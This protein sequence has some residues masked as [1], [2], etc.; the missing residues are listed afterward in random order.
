MTV[1]KLNHPIKRSLNGFVGDMMS[2]LPMAFGS[3]KENNLSPLVNIK[4]TP[5][6]YELEL[7]APG[8]SKDD[9]K[10]ALEKNIITIS[11]V[12]VSPQTNETEKQVRRE[13]SVKEFERSFTIDD[14]VAGENI[15][16]VYE[17][18]ILKLHLPKN[19]KTK[20]VKKEITIG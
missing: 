9:F 6:S 8:R 15:T 20:S 17:N 4:E 13:F 16:A 3:Y 10:I 19:E 11:A 12:N 5:D 2:E 7:V 18:G 1:L 14:T